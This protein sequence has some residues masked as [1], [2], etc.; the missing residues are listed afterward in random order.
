[1]DMNENV[2]TLAFVV[3]AVVV[4]AVAWLAR[5]T[6][7]DITEAREPGAAV[8][9]E[10]DPLTAASLEIV[11]YDADTASVKPFKVAQVNNQW[12]IPSHDNYP[13][14]A[15]D[16]VAQAATSLLGLKIL[17]VE[18]QSPGDHA[19]YGVVE[20]DPKK[21]K[22]GDTGVGKKVT[23]RDKSNK[24]LVSLVI[25]KEVPDREGLRYVRRAGQDPVYVVEIK[26]DKISTK[27]E[28]WIEKD[29][30]KLNSWDIKRV[31][32]NDYS[33]DILAGTQ[34]P[35][36]KMAVEYNDTGDP[37]W[38]LVEDLAFRGN[39][40][41]PQG[42]AE[43]EEVNATKLDDM[44]NALDDLKIVDVSPKPQGLSADL[45]L[46][47]SMPKDDEGV[48]S[49]AQRGF[50]PAK[51]GNQFELLSNE[52]EFRVLMKD[53]VQYVLRFG[54]VAST[55]AAEEKPEGSDAAKKEGEDASSDSGTGLNRYLMVA[56]EFNRDSIEKP[57]LEP[58][59][60][61]K[62]AEKA[63][64]KAA[65]ETK[66][67]E[68][69]A[70]GE[71][72]PAEEKKDEAAKDDTAKKEAEKSAEELKAERERIEKENKQKQDEYQEKLKKGEE[73]VKEL[74]A[75]FAGWYYVISDSVYQKIHLTRADIVKKKEEKKEEA[76]D[77]TTG[78]AAT[79]DMPAEGGAPGE[80]DAAKEESEPTFTPEDFQELKT[81]APKEE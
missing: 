45:K 67:E 32:I 59:P 41:E 51:I 34:N 1:M 22:S 46:G 40:Y 68:E 36:G 37:R 48:N 12:S 79:G 10:F 7:E 49:L 26:T 21:L 74:N 73:R 5:P 17:S 28:D 6:Y 61:E 50:Y 64:E 29:L 20:P 75:R 24:S 16:Q 4:A 38:K 63:D 47:E 81:D 72:K 31:E 27:F 55:G 43:D 66:S 3:V 15:Q 62:P 65:P 19:M 39:E 44:R 11:E 14:D 58:L 60:D 78:D 2:K 53:G 13:A 57:K 76:K 33:V 23:L 18:S 52:G 9:Q 25:G 35:R 70:E 30:L 71:A 69:P 56:A 42:L 80:T 8:F 54:Q 77:G